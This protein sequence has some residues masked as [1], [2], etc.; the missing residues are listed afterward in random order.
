[1]QPPVDDEPSESPPVPPFDEFAAIIFLEE[2]QQHCKVGTT[3]ARNARRAATNELYTVEDV[4]RYA[5]TAANAAAMISKIL[6]PIPRRQNDY[7]TEDEFRARKKF[8][9][10]RGRELCTMLGMSK[11]SVLNRSQVRN[12]IEHFDE[13]L[14]RRLMTPG[15]IMIHFT[16]GSRQ[17]ARIDGEEG[18][19]FYLHRYDPRTTEYAIL[20]DSIRLAEVQRAMEDLSRRADQELRRL[21]AKRLEDIRRANLASLPHAD[22]PGSAIDDNPR[23]RDG[24]TPFRRSSRYESRPVARGRG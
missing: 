15:R 10:N 23:E 17:A 16:I 22:E 19:R 12:G 20:E 11:S 8:T 21:E 18:G 9:K 4:F 14:D 6:W 3:A 13:R 24:L 1:M 7:E 2:L 5:G